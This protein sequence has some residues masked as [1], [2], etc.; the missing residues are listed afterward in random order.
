MNALVDSNPD[1]TVPTLK[2]VKVKEEPVTPPGAR[3]IPPRPRA[4]QESPGI[5]SVSPQQSGRPQAFPIVRQALRTEPESGRPQASPVVR[6]A[7]RTEPETGNPQ[8]SP[9]VRHAIK[10]ET[11]K[12]II[13]SFSLPQAGGI[14]I[15]H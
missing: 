10:T 13:K 3:S 2:M 12:K 7:L 1:D 14:E 4:V 9:I 11:E 15:E 6:Q 5:K 8:A